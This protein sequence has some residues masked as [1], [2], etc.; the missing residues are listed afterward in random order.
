[1]ADSKPR[2]LTSDAKLDAF[3]QEVTAALREGKRHQTPG[4][5]TFSTCTRK[6]T[7]V[8]AA[9]RMAMFRASAD[10]REHV[11]G[12]P[13]PTVTGP[14]AEVVTLIID[15]MKIRNGVEVPSLGLMAVVPELGKKPR[16][17]FHG[18]DELNDVLAAS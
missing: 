4:L 11:M 8:R 6:A 17:I 14:H 16:L 9:C 10:F 18:A 15:V 3:V 5:G 13:L 2:T 1:M 12:G 7:A